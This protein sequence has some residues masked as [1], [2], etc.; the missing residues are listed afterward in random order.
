MP[1]LGTGEIFAKIDLSFKRESSLVIFY[2]QLI[3]H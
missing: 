1:T 2:R 3:P